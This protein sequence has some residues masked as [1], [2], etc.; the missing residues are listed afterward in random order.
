MT[1]REAM[2]AAIR[3]ALR[4]PEAAERALGSA[5]T[6]LS[7][8]RLNGVMPPIAPEDRVARFE[9]ELKNVNGS[10]YRVST[11]AELDETLRTIIANSKAASVVLTRNPLLASVRLPERLH[12]CG[13]PFAMWPEPSHGATGAG[14]TFR[15]QCFS[16]E[17]GISGVDFVL[18]ET[19][20]LILSSQTEGSQLASLAP[21]VHVALYRRRQVLSSLDEILDQFPLSAGPGPTTQGRSIVFITGPSRTAD[22]EQILIRGVHGPREV[23]AILVEE[24]CL[25]EIGAPVGPNRVRPGS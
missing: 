3:T 17:I 4:R 2:L 20:S 12:S 1:G 5:P 25:A 6:A 19:G 22:I 11:P 15:D 9:T 10:S 14:K 24:S 23:H 7:P 21:P 18:A 8:A 13:V 16:A